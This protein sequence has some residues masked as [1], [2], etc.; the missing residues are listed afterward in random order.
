MFYDRAKIEIK[1]GRGGNGCVSFRREKY[2]PKG[3]PD[4][5]DGGDGGD[6]IIEASLRL[7]DLM[8]F[9]RQR[10]FRAGNGGHGQGA[11][12]QGRR[13]DDQVVQVPLGT[14]IIDDNGELLADLT[15]DGQRFFVAH[16]GGGGRG[17][18]RFA[19]STRRAPRFSELGLA[20][21]E[22]TVSLEL[23]LLA[24]AGLLGFPNAGKSS[25]LRVISH[26]KPK[27]ADYPFTTVAPMLG[28]V[29][30]PD[31]R[32]QF[33]VADIPGLL[34][35]A[36]SGVGLGDEFLVH[37]ER[38][39]LLIH[40]V[41]ATGYYG[42]D[43]LD[44]F[45]IINRELAGF[46]P[47][48][49][50]KWQLVVVNKVDL[51]GEEEAARLVD[52]L[53]AEIISRCRTHDPAFAWLLED[54]EG[55]PDEVDGSRAVIRISA[56]TGAGTKNLTR[57]VYG[58]LKRAWLREPA[59]ITAEP[60]GHMTYRPGADDHWEVV[61]QEGR[62]R[63]AGQLVERLVARTDFENEEAVAFLQERL[64][65]L[66]V[67]DALRQAGASPGEDVVI[68]EMEFELW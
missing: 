7:R 1:A 43:P 67:S 13:G 28:T 66:G 40:L 15:A 60:E 33:T 35:G 61:Q 17:N 2:V 49:A 23:K 30:E 31:Q 45:A 25:L 58:L 12:K 29:E 20:G 19:T 62:Y 59:V 32:N 37:L 22:L 68:G 4:G 54:A 9:Q 5:G 38:T 10:H 50:A 41:D 16:G 57:R 8:Y 63:V 14:Q 3:G 47:E 48:I 26:A 51:V 55:D 11:N 34:E 39:R 18:A 36:S 21:E 6:V 46:S 44:N 65:H 24:D 27:V 64:E 52:L 42:K 56:A 53:S